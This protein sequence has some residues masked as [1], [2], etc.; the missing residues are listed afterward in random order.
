MRYSRKKVWL[1]IE[2]VRSIS[3]SLSITHCRLISS[4]NW[5]RGETATQKGN[6]AAI[7]KGKG[8]KAKSERGSKESSQSREEVIGGEADTTIKKRAEIITP[9]CLRTST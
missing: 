1:E 4:R 3:L 5:K 6:K 8:S 2:K 9:P 7:P